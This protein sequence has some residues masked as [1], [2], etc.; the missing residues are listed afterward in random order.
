MARVVDASGSFAEVLRHAIEARGLG[1]ERIRDHLRGRGVTASAATSSYWQSGRSQPGL[2]TIWPEP[3][4]APLLAGLDTRWDGPDRR[5][6]VHRHD[7]AAAAAPVVRALHGC[8]TGRTLADA[9]AG[10]VGDELQTDCAVGTTGIGW[11]RPAPTEPYPTP[12]P[13]GSGVNC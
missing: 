12:A 7:D 3:P 9:S 5:V 2:D 6:M 10:L 4:C 11:R 13:V 1:L 8:R